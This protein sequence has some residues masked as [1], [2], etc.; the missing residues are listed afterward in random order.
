MRLQSTYLHISPGKFFKLFLEAEQ[1]QTFAEYAI[2][3][4]F[5]V[6]LVFGML[7]N[8][9]NELIRMYQSVIDAF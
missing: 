9:A 2:I 7:T 1:A 3:F 8:Y 6:L 5:V 4:L